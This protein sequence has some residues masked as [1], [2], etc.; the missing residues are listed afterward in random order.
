MVE[1]LKVDCV[2]EPSILFWYYNHS[3]VPFS[4]LACGN[5]LD[6]ALVNV[7]IQ[8]VFYIVKEVKW[9][10]LGGGQREGLC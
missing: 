3:G 10:W 7:V 4:R 2:I 9:D 1:V 8:F 5:P 6:D